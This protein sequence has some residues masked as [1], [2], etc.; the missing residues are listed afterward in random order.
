MLSEVFIFYNKEFFD[1]QNKI[2]HLCL[3]RRVLKS[4]SNLNSM[5]QSPKWIIKKS[6][7]IYTNFIISKKNSQIV[8][9]N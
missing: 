9:E 3:I 7:F 2:R 1:L 5:Y 4:L 8:E 6:V